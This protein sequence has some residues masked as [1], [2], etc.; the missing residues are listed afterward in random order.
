MRVAVAGSVTAFLTLAALGV[1]TV[2]AQQGPP[3]EQGRQG[4]QSRP[5]DAMLQACTAK[6]EAQSCS[7]SGDDGA[8]TT[9]TCR[10]PQGRL[11]ACVPEG[12]RRG[13]PAGG[14]GGPPK[15][16]SN[17]GNQIP[18]TQ[19]YTQGV[20]CNLSGSAVN[21]QVGLTSAFQWS[22]A[23]GQRTLQANGIPN[24]SVGAFPNP[25]N[26]N[27]LSLQ[28][29]SFA[30]SLSPVAY[31]GPGGRAKEG[32]MGINGIKFDPGTGGSCGD[33]IAD[34]KDCPLGPGGGGRWNIEALGQD[35][36]DFGEDANHA[37]VQPSGAYHYHGVPEGLLSPAAREGKA[38]ALI[39]WA[40]DGFPVYARYGFPGASQ[41][42]GSLKL[43][44][45]SYRLKQ[46]PDTGRPSTEIVPMGAFSQDWEYVAGLGDLDE[47]NGRFGT[48]PEFPEGIYHYYA[49]DDYPYVQRC[50]K[51]SLDSAPQQRMG[52]EQGQRREGGRGRGQGGRGQRGEGNRPPRN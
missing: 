21:E 7:F 47:C 11:L 44:Q 50:V 8:T 3:R 1:V 30:T 32:V 20:L 2:S 15:G 25:G 43:M 23:N 6:Q 28:Q 51:G 19:A 16:E 38:M 41:M 12:G 10:A 24:H 31:S 40:A 13:G 4:G 29:V 52:G 46:A 14:E 34:P 27:A 49:T 9:G 18:S 37:H 42:F 35:T 26:P 5:T 22:C 17:S 45:P 36:F 48:T 33:D 39:G